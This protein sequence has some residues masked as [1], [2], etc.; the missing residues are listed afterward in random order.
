MNDRNATSYAIAFHGVPV[1]YAGV[2]GAGGLGLPMGPSK[3]K[4]GMVLQTHVS[5]ERYHKIKLQLSTLLFI[6]INI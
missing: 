2:G 4:I 1:A 5:S 3:K 6:F